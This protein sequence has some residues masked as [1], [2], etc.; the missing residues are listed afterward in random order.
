M[1]GN[2]KN[3]VRGIFSL[4]AS[5][6]IAS[7]M[8]A[9]SPLADRQTIWIR[10]VNSQAHKPRKVEANGEMVL[11]TSPTTKNDDWIAALQK[12]LARSESRWA[13]ADATETYQQLCRAC[14]T[15]NRAIPQAR[16]IEPTVLFPLK[17]DV[18]ARATQRHSIVGWQAGSYSLTTSTHF[19][20]ASQATAKQSNEVAKLCEQTFSIWQQLFFSSWCKAETL[21]QVIEDQQ[22]LSASN[23]PKFQIVVFRNREAYIKQLQQIEPN[24]AV[25]TGYFSPKLM[26]VFCYWDDA[27]SVASLRHELTH[28]FF[29]QATG[30]E[31][32]SPEEL[33]SDFWIVE[34][35]ALY[36]ES[37]QITNSGGFDIA[38]IGGWDA[39]R[40]QPARYRRLHD[41]TW[42][43]WDEF[44][45]ANNERFRTGAEIKHW[46]SQAAGL[47]HFWMDQEPEKRQ[48]FLDYAMQVYRGSP[49]AKSPIEAENDEKLRIGYD[50]FL[51]LPELKLS[52]HP[53]SAE[54][55]ELVL[56][57]CPVSSQVLL[58]W[59]ESKRTLDWLDL[60]FTKIDDRL[61]LQS[62][63]LPSQK[64]WDVRRLNVE[65]T[66]VTDASLPIFARMT[67]LEE[68]DL[69]RCDITDKGLEALRG[70]KMLR[71]LWL[72]GNTGITNEGLTILASLP[73][74][75]LTDISETSITEDGWKNLVSKSPRLRRKKAVP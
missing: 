75:E 49:Q 24:V 9:Q 73:R 10:A 45:R 18:Q 7:T 52:E 59:P 8:F 23:Q 47:T 27:T 69:S 51:L 54:S 66:R 30:E 17:F 62:S 57:R 64:M 74:L 48:A 71:T 39:T 21:Q 20:I 55:K 13:D 33:R 60:S 4:A 41:E 67:R 12:K 28:Q 5:V 58:D 3:T 16:L 50:Q 25:S 42:I 68:L 1:L 44:R 53:P 46:Y 26:A 63:E 22:A 40:L 38:T 65:S 14:V 34:G 29:S 32:V 15:G 72:T 70:H 35:L 2:T 43:P 31:T 19:T 36:M 6:A 37:I 56:S 11:P 61:F